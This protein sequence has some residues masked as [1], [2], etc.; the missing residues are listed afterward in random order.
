MGPK[1]IYLILYNLS[2]CVGWAFIF[3]LSV[4]TVA[5]GMQ[6][7]LSES[8]SK[9]Y[10]AGNL[11]TLLTYCQTAAL[12]EIVHSIVGIVPS[13]VVIVTMQ[14]SSRIFAVVAIT[15]SPQAQSKCKIQCHAVVGNVPLLCSLRI[16][17]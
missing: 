2:L 15:F 8:L 17:I 13:P 7:G 4:K 12:M 1:E 5:E 11:A 6:D 3:L 16:I 10:G 14:V 9:V